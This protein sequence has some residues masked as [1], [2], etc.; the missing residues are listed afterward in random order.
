MSREYRLFLQDTQASC[1]KILRYTQGMSFDQFKQ[2]DLVYDA[3]LR[4]IEII[5]QAVKN[6]PE[7]VRIEHSEIDWRR[8]AGLR[9]IVTHHYFGIH[10]EMV[11]D[12]IVNKVPELLDQITEILTNTD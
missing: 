8:I 3:V 5:G 4:N 1:L 7:L 11:W 6:I 9:D 12:V 2:N 10:D